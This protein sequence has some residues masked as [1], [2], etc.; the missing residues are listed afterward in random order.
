MRVLQEWCKPF[1]GFYVYAPTR[2][3][4]SAKVRALIDSLVEKRE[5]IAALRALWPAGP[6]N[7]GRWTAQRS[8]GKSAF[9]LIESTPQQIRV[10]PV[11]Q[12]D[13]RNRYAD[14]LTGSNPLRFERLVG[15]LPTTMLRE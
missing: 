5:A 11:F 1:A 10:E 4:M 12:R 14:S 13:R 7:G 6:S 2:A 8:L 3:Q 9:R 15:A